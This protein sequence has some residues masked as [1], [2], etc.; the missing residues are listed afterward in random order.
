MS[1]LAHI[2]EPYSTEEFLKNKWTSQAVFIA[3]ETT[4]KFAHLF[5]W[6]KLNDILNFHE[7]KYPE[8]RLALNGKVLEE[9]DNRNLINLCHEGATLIINGVHKRMPEIA[10]FSSELRYELGYSTQVNAYCSWPGRQGFSSHYDTHEVFVLQIAGSK[11]WHVFPDTIKYPLPDQKS[12]SFLP[13]AGD[14]YLSCTLGPG[15]LLYIPRGHWHYA[16]AL[17]EPSLHLTLGVHCQTGIDLLDWLVGELRQKPQWRRSLPLRLDDSDVST[18]VET[19]VRDLHQYLGDRNIPQDYTSY[20]DSLGKP[21]AK[22]SLPYQAGFNL[23][24]YG[25]ETR[26]KRPQFQRVR[27]SELADNSGYLITMSGKEVSLKGV[28]PALVENLFTREFFT[29]QDVINWLPGFDWEI[30]IIPLLTCLVLEGIIFVDT[31]R[32]KDEG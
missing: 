20:L 16:V 19:L 13:P 5:S 3:S 8:L 32:M 28:T 10:S 30:D 17:D 12:A 9:A 18:S 31:E 22:Y 11:Q 24:P 1:L 26:F 23:F 25:V 14:P 21:I 6:E 7:L 15:D 2:L 29:G 4:N 27:V